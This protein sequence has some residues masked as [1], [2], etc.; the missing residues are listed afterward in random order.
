MLL[1]SFL[2]SYGRYQK[3]MG[4]C[5]FI[6]YKGLFLIARFLEKWS[7]NVLK[8]LK[9]KKLPWVC[10]QTVF[11]IIIMSSHIILRSR[12]QSRLEK[13]QGA[14]WDYMELCVSQRIDAAHTTSEQ[15]NSSSANCPQDST[16]ITA[17]TSP[18][19]KGGGEQ[20]D[21]HHLA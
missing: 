15:Y 10:W 9:S 20:G 16:Y 5:F 2:F 7:L 17:A 1:F 13:E 19:F 18:A 11:I 21:Q 14:M 3:D 8:Y 12:R 4:K 6:G